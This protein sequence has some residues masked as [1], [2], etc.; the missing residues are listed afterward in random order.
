MRGGEE[1]EA[2]EEEEEEEEGSR[3][4]TTPRGEKMSSARAAVEERILFT[5]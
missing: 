3:G 1:T 2:E 4:W 5:Q